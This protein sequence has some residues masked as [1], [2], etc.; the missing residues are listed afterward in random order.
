M[1]PEEIERNKPRGR[2]TARYRANYL[3]EQE[4]VY[5]YQKLAEIEADWLYRRAGWWELSP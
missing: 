1:K 3:A 5:L 2:D 4:G